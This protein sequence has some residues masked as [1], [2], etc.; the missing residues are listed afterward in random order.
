ME[1]SEGTHPFPLTLQPLTLG[2][3][4]LGQG[5]Q[6]GKMSVFEGQIGERPQAFGGLQFWGV[7]RQE[8]QME[9]FRIGQLRGGMPP[10][11]VQNQHD[12]PA[13]SRAGITGKSVE[14]RLKSERVH[15]RHQPILAF[16]RLR[17]D[18]GVHVEP[19]EAVFHRYRWCFASLS[20][21]FPDNGLQS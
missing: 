13:L 14:H 16:P 9:A 19:G 12:L 1:E 7:R 4:Q 15:A 20:P 17:T 21:H 3:E 2:R 18:E 5:I 11:P 6:G 10:R 8:D